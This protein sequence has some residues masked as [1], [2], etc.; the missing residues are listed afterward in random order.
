MQLPELNID[1]AGI[2]TTRPLYSD[3]TDVPC[4]IDSVDV[5]EN[6]AKN[7]YNMVVVFASTEAIPASVEGKTVPTGNKLTKYY[8][9]QASEK[10]EAADMGDKFKEDIA[11][12]FDAAFQTDKETRP[13]LTEETLQA[14]FG[15]EVLITARFRDDE[16]YGQSNEVGR[17]KS[18]S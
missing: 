9:L 1:I 15:K 10:Q 2:D 18:L 13:N 7:G 8:P 6:K 4:V 11:L 17:V 16:T 14:L 3:R 5:V 12:L